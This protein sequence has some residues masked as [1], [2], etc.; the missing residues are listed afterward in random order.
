[1]LLR[2]YGVLV[3]IICGLTLLSL[4]FHSA[5]NACTALSRCPYCTDWVLKTQCRDFTTFQNF[6]QGPVECGKKIFVPSKF[7]YIYSV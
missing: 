2:S 4:C 7:G 3:E 1:M 5:S 6:G